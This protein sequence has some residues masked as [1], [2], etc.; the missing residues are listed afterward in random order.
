MI[1]R[2]ME[3]RGSKSILYKPT[4]HKYNVVK[5]QRV[6]GSWFL[7]EKTAVPIW[8]N[9]R[10]TLKGLERGYQVKILTKQF[11]NKSYSTLIQKI[12]P[13]FITGFSDA[14]ASFIVSIYKNTSNILGWRISLAFTIH[15]HN[16]DI[17]LL[18]TIKNTLGVGIVRLDS[19]TTAVF[20]V[21]SLSELQ[22]IIEFFDKYPLVSEKYSDFL[23]FKNCYKILKNQEHL[24]LKGFKE[25][26]ALKSVLNK[27]L[28]EDLKK[29]FTN[30]TPVPRP[31]NI[32]T[33]IPNPNWI[34]G[35]ASG[36]STFS[37]SIENSSTSK[38]GKRVRLIYGTCLHIRDRNLLVLISN[39]FNN[40]NF[41]LNNMNKKAVIAK[42]VNVHTS[43]NICLLQFK[44][45]SDIYNKIIPF[46]DKHPI[47]GVKSLDFE[48]F[49]KVANLVE[50]KEHLSKDGLKKI[51]TIVK[52]MNLNR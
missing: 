1:E 50:S 22:I 19:P 17:A 47:H 27:G 51:Y 8:R 41:G 5:E 4:S 2:E 20:R 43:K 32:N 10:C 37:I 3:Y 16:K 15:I 48:D 52:S 23:L 49:K 38:V 18:E 44:N 13:W 6:D 39:Y 7:H 21:N 31:V 33:N 14:E 40:L 45:T 29:V 25:I 46:F 28:S 30:I 24:T 42:D 35:F 26:L 9:L 12:D 11:I 36:D 34:S